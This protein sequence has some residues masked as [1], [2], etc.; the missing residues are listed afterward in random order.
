MSE[1]KNWAD[2]QIW[3]RYAREDL[4]AA[5]ELITA[6]ITQRNTC[7]LAQQAAE[8]SIKAILV[9]RQVDFP[10]SH[11]LDALINLM[12]KGWTVKEQ[13]WDASALSQWAVEARYPGDWPETTASDALAAIAT[14]KG[15]LQAVVA[16]FRRMGL[17]EEIPVLPEEH[18]PEIPGSQQER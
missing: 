13:S 4:Q 15:I 11:D 6:G 10:K 12:P 16:D 2:A 9:F 8:K 1:P 14:A 18:V 5:E 3:L 7:F 17:C